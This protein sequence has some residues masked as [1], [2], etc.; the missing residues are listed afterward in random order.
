MTRQDKI[1]ALLAMPFILASNWVF[2]WVASKF[3]WWSWAE[4]VVFYGLGATG[5]VAVLAAT[6]FVIMAPREKG[7]ERS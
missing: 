6:V 5:T 3:V 2:A 4:P 7:V 1:G